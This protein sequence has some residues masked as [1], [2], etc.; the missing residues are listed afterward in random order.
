[1]ERYAVTSSTQAE[2][3]RLEAAGF[4]SVQAEALLQMIGDAQ[5]ALA[6]KQ[7]VAAVQGALTQDIADLR[8]E[9]RQ[10]I[11]E[12][13]TE[14]RQD[15]AEVR[16][17]LRQD[18][19]EVRTELKQDIAE[20]RTELKQDIA[21]V[22]TDLSN[23]T[24]TVADNTARI[25]ALERAMG[26]LRQEVRDRFESFRL[27]IAGQMDGLRAEMRALKWMFGVMLAMMAPMAGGIIALALR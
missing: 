16:T 5:E 4:D 3:R 10:D 9:L 7:D 17:E 14:L 15:I 22:R 20:V 27:E 23:L 18:I 13:R 21:E 24:T 1:M 2:R 26:A 11:A 12:V 25:D 6:T 19:A 8:T